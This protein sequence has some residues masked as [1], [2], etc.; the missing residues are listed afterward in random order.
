MMKPL[1]LAKDAACSVGRAFK[2]AFFDFIGAFGGGTKNL[3]TLIKMQ[4]KEQFNF[5]RLDVK[6]SSAFSILVST[7]FT[8]LKFVLVTALCYVF[9]WAAASQHVF[10]PFAL[11][12]PVGVISLVVVFMILTSAVSCVVGLTKSLYYSR[13]NAILLTLPCL[14]TQVYLSKFIIFFFFEVKRNFS[15]LVPF[16]LAF[17]IS[18]GTYSVG[19]YVWM[20]FCVIIFSLFTVSVGALLSIPAMWI[21]NFFRLHKWMQITLFTLIFSAL[22]VG[23]FIAVSIMPDKID[24]VANWEVTQQYIQNFFSSFKTDFAP[25]YDTS[26]IF[27]GEEGFLISDPMSFPFKAT[28]LRFLALFGATLV[29]FILGFVIVRPLFYKMASKP[30]EYLKLKVKPRRNKVHSRRVSAVRNEF[31]ITFKTPDRIIANIGIFFAAPML[32]FFLNKFLF[33]MDTSARGDSMIAAFTVLVVL[34]IS[35][36]ANTAIASIFSRDGRSSYLLKTQ[37]S[38]YPILVLSKLLPN[39]VFVGSSIIATFVVLLVASKIGTLNIILLT[40]FV[41]LT[42]LAHM[43]Y[44]AELD[45]MNPQVELYST[46]GR[47]ESNP[48]ETKATVSAFI[49]AFLA[50]AAT[51]LLLLQPNETNVYLKFSIVALAALIYRAYLFFENLK[52]YYKEK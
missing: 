6:G 26:L 33:A 4:L 27:L 13:D 19:A 47:V 17:F 7:V 52:L 49:I 45:L 31:L 28:A 34:L 10:H 5:K 18:N 2:G 35:L 30:F 22:I 21:A 48:N 46:V 3:V 32:V 9:I 29:C 1:I 36:N 12:L 24:L 11:T 43:L 50:A 38:K 40:L 41:G 44:C 14:P 23:F 37:P 15:F 25:I 51:F 8:I 42:Y 39:T 16:I 20:L